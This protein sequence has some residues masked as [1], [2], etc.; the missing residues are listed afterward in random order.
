LPQTLACPEYRR[1]RYGI[2]YSV[3]FVDESY[4]ASRRGDT[5]P[6]NANSAVSQVL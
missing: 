3:E 2:E 4:V 5:E 1:R 6:T